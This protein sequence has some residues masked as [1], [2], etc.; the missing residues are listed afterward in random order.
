M[1]WKR[2]LPM[3]EVMKKALLLVP[4]GLETMVNNQLE[5]APWR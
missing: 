1:T 4:T 2:N 3:I 5:E